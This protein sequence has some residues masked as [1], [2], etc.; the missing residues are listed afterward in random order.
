[1]K[2]DALDFYVLQDSISTRFWYTFALE[3][4]RSINDRLFLLQESGRESY[5][6]KNLFFL[7]HSK[8]RRLRHDEQR[9]CRPR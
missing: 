9:R 1:M 2:H 3:R 4:Y 8:H 6:V 5:A 7:K